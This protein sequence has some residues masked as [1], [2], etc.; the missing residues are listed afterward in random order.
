MSFPLKK[1]TKT[2]KPTTLCQVSPKNHFFLSQE[3]GR[4][5][6]YFS[7][8]ILKLQMQKWLCKKYSCGYLL[9][10]WVVSYYFGMG[11]KNLVCATHSDFCVLTAGPFLTWVCSWVKLWS[12]MLTLEFHIKYCCWKTWV[13]LSALLE[14]ERGTRCPALSE[15]WNFWK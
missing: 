8:A 4:F 5:S 11:Q 13:I 6:L 10:F 12:C 3:R 2:S 7:S 9:H 15:D 14:V 1:K